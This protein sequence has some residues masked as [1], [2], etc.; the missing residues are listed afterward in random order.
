MAL[1]PLTNLAAFFEL[2]PEQ[3]RRIERVVVLGG[4]ECAT[5]L[6]FPPRRWPRIHDANIF[7]DP[8]SAAVV[9][10][11]ARNLTLVPFEVYS[12]L[13]VTRDDWRRV[14]DGAAGSYLRPR[15]SVWIWFWTRFVRIDGAPVFDAA[16]VMAVARP[17]LVS[18][19]P[20][21]ARV[22]ERLLIVDEHRGS[23]AV[24]VRRVRAL[25][26]QAAATLVDRIAGRKS[27]RDR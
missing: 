7:K 8:A 23:G 2:Y 20:A 27:P 13:R 12:R 22:E 17:D 25:H 4:Q 15:T 18:S 16:A 6:A 24:R 3:A 26:P 9:L 21:F 1:G 11:R 14:L 19:A 10:R 5:E